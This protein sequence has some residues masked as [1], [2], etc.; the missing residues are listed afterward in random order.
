MESYYACMD[1]ICTAR[2]AA[3]RRCACAGR[4]KSIAEAEAALEQATEDLITVSGELALR[5]ETKGK[6]VKTAFR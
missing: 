5:I 4:V 2:N 3:Q 6:D 1:E